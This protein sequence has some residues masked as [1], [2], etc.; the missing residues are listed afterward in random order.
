MKQRASSTDEGHDVQRIG[1]KE[2]AGKWV[3]SQKAL[4]LYMTLPTILSFLA[5]RI[6][7]THIKQPMKFFQV[8]V[9]Y[10]T[11]QAYNETDNGLKVQNVS[12]LP[13][14]KWDEKMA[15]PTTLYSSKSFSN[16][17]VK[18]SHDIHAK[19]P[20]NASN[21]SHSLHHDGKKIDGQNIDVDESTT[22]EHLLL[23]IK[24]VDSGFLDDEERLSQ[25]LVDVCS[26]A[27]LALISYHCHLM[28]PSG[29]T[30]VGV[31]TRGHI[32]FHTWPDEGVILMD[33]YITE[34][35]SI[36]KTQAILPILSNLERL[37]AVPHQ[38]NSAAK[39]NVVSMPRVEWRHK[40]RGFS[41]ADDYF[42]TNH[43]GNDLGDEVL[44]SWMEYKAKI[45]STETKFQRVDIYD[46]IPAAQSLYIGN[47]TALDQAIASGI[48]SPERTLF[49]D[50][51]TQSK[52][53]KDEVYHEALVHPA[54]MTHPNPKRVAIVGGGEG[55]TL[56]EVLKHGTV[57][58]VAMIEIDGELVEICREYLPSMSDCSD[59]DGST[60]SCF[61]DSRVELII[62]DAT[63]W[64]IDNFGPD[65][66]DKEEE[67]EDEDVEKFDVIIMDALD[68]MFAIPEF[69]D[70]LYSDNDFMPSIFEA[71]AEDGIV[72]LQMGASPAEMEP[73]EHMSPF[74]KRSEVISYVAEFADS[75]H[76]YEEGNC[77]FGFPWSF[78]IACREE[79][80]SESFHRSQAEMEISMHRRLLTS[81]SGAK[82]LKFFDG[83]VLK[84]YQVPPKSWE[85][86]YCRQTPV[87]KG[88][89]LTYSFD[90]RVPHFPSSIFE[91][92][93]SSLGEHVG[94]GVFVAVDIPR[95]A[96]MGQELAGNE[97]HFPPRSLDIIENMMEADD[98]DDSTLCLY[99]YVEGYGYDFKPHGIFVDQD[100]MTFVN[101]GCFGSYN[102]GTPYEEVLALYN[103][104]TQTF[105]ISEQNPSDYIS[106]DEVVNAVW[107]PAGKRRK[108]S[109]LNNGCTALRPIKMGEELFADYN[110]FTDIHS[111][112]WEI[113]KEEL[114]SQCMG[115]KIG[116]VVAAEHSSKRSKETPCEE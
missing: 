93:T 81:R 100:I 90:P 27:K 87:P 101:H 2:K 99:N 111:P 103:E 60:Q 23:D 79:D 115:T 78:L 110:Y 105:S 18:S 69:C 49:L 39:F 65:D 3:V 19:F 35:S 7:R 53:N 28:V 64:F 73:D 106:V 17:N 43:L 67:K 42:E 47:N 45:I 40:L 32:S 14:I 74:K 34:R 24:H 52:L 25:A 33:L 89:S 82:P 94:R 21:A 41:D 71:L 58:H 4:V 109:E 88:C 75:M 91:V 95:G 113:E 116:L 12:S 10:G 102:I 30:C 107:D 51:V 86:V 46:F 31:L 112:Y 84:S 68:P 22:G 16:P 80:C 20:F 44:E 59:I 62:E 92:K 50:G 29:V 104:T 70:G 85:T 96:L 48:V 63:D 13:S 15:V 61:D 76:M 36:L 8:P 37:F 6:L 26:E 56:R 66:E 72:V 54:M 108:F 97:V 83:A 11:K 55:A 5:G 57:E 1:Q 114:K 98:S 38:Q 9:P 77:G